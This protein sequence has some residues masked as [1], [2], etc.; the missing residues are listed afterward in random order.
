MGSQG[1]AAFGAWLQERIGTRS[2][3]QVAAYVGVSASTVSRWITGESGVHYR[4]RRR[5]A[6][7]LGVALEEIVSRLPPETASPT[8]VSADFADPHVLRELAHVRDGFEKLERLGVF[9]RR[10]P[11]PPR[12]PDAAPRVTLEIRPTGRPRTLRPAILPD[13]RY[14]HLGLT[15]GLLVWFDT[16]VVPEPGDLVRAGD[17]EPPVVMPYAEA[18]PARI[19][20]VVRLQQEVR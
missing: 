9:V 2:R 1:S 8:E 5:L 11:T 7:Y 14:A 19:T 3:G 6:E 17:N 13:D 10:P 20:A 16:R 18:D 15:E 12:P 4:N